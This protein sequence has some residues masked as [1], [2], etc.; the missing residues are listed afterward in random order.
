MKKHAKNA[1]FDSIYTSQVR[2]TAGSVVGEFIDLAGGKSL[3]CSGKMVNILS[4]FR[5]NISICLFLLFVVDM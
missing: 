3:D 5:F 4:I 2:D 1:I